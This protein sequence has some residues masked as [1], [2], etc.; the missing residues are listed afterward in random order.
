MNIRNSIKAVII[1]EDSVLLTK[2]R[3]ASG[4][5]YIFPGGGQDHGEVMHDTLRRE[6]MEELGAEIEVGELLYVREYIGKNHEFAE[7]DAHA[8][9]VEFY[10]HCT[11]KDDKLVT[12]TQP[13]PKQIGVEWLRIDQLQEY[14][15]YPKRLTNYFIKKTSSIYL[16]DIN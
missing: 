10:F 12:P 8:H 16:G 9:Q 5:F 11:L 1:K 14:D 15:V 4:D 7:T 3:G 13:D 2:N 6:C